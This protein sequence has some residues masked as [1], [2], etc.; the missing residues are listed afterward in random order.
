[1]TLDIRQEIEEAL[2]DLLAVRKSLKTISIAELSEHAQVSRRTF[3]RYYTSKERVLTAYIDRLLDNYFRQ[4][5]TIELTDFENIICFFMDYWTKEAERMK[6]L[7]EAELL[8]LVPNRFYKSLTKFR[9][10]IVNTPWHP[11]NQDSKQL[12]YDSRYLV[13]GLYSILDEWLRCDY[14]EMDVEEITRLALKAS[15][16]ML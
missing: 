15:K 8:G 16:R 11:D 12:I 10:I 1:M 4:I 7:Q 6:V 9:D 2:F 13:G 3:Y 5:Q 14:P